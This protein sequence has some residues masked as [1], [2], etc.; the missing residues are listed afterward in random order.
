[1]SCCSDDVRVCVYVLQWANHD[2]SLK[3]EEATKEALLARIEEKVAA[4][5]GT[6]I[7]WQYL[8]DAVALLRKVCHTA[9]SQAAAIECFP[10]SPSLSSSQCRYTLKYTYPFA[11][12]LEG[13]GKPLVSGV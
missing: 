11:Y 1:M 6:W 2:Q 8:L 9:S 3:L 12:Y 10:P 4:A 5:E 7:D 13:D